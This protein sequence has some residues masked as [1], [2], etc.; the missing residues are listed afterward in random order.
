[1]LIDD[2]KKI[3]KKVERLHNRCS[4]KKYIIR[5]GCEH[6]YQLQIIEMHTTIL[7]IMLEKRVQKKVDYSEFDYL[8]AVQ[9]KIPVVKPTEES[10]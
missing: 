9:E 7:Q 4:T 10:T 8:F 3:I 5:H 1:M 6:S 2:I